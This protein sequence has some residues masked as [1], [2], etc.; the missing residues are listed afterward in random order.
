MVLKA[1]AK[2]GM[3][4]EAWGEGGSLSGGKAWRWAIPEDQDMKSTYGGKC[5]WGKVQWGG[6]GPHW[7]EA[8]GSKSSGQSPKGEQA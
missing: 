8:M 5:Y 7:G 4:E 3:G 2:E 6:K 1:R